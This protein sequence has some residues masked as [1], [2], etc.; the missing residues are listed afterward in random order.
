MSQCVGFS[1]NNVTFLNKLSLLEENKYDLKKEIFQ[2]FPVKQL[3]GNDN[4]TTLRSNK[5]HLKILHFLICK[6]TITY[7]V[8]YKYT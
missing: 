4:L 7:N 3:N 8:V 6:A 2:L 1:R 5:I